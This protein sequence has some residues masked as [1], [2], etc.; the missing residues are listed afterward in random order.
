MN[1]F[2]LAIA[3]LCVSASSMALYAEEEKAEKKCTITEK[4]VH[5]Y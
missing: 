5:Y 3:A 1:A 2:L 4:K